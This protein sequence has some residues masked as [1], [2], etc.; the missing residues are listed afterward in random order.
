MHTPH[1]ILASQSFG[2]REL[3]EKFHLPFEVIPSNFEEDMTK[4][5]P[6]HELVQELALGKAQDVARQYPESMVIGADTIVVFDNKRLGKPKSE[7]EAFEVIKS[8]CGNTHEL[9]T[10]VALV[11]GEKTLTDYDRTI[12]EFQSLSDREIE[13]YITANKDIVTKCA[14]GYTLDKQASAFLKKIEGNH[15]TI[16]GM[17]MHK[18]RL[19]LAEFDVSLFAST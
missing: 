2:R 12:V 16:I 14:G 15:T 1:I 10:G 6:H 19:M 4:D 8:L 3:L 11:C 9:Y 7:Q 5:M 17:P 13:T 18:L